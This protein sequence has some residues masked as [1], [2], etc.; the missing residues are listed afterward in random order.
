YYKLNY[1]FLE[2]GKSTPS[3]MDGFTDGPAYVKVD[4]KGNKHV[5]MTFTN[6]DMI[7][8]FKVNGENTKVVQENKKKDTR[9]VEFAVNNLT[10]KQ[11]GT[12]FVEVPGMYATEHE[13]DLVFDT[14]T[15]SKAKDYPG[16]EKVPQKDSINKVDQK[17]NDIPKKPVNSDLNPKDLLA[18]EYKIDYSF[19][20]KG[21]NN[22]SIMDGFTEGPA[23]VKVDKK[24][25]KRVAITFTSADYIKG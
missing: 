4:K 10:K 1:T 2:K 19:L 16:D 5:A 11:A 22:T 23:H 25:N 18:G 21:T 13:I 24:G 3:T 9:T 14:D 12:V 6:A 20:E 7:K 15:L 17:G 8:Y